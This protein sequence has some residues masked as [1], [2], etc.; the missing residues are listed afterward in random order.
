MCC[1]A[2]CVV[3]LFETSVQ[4]SLHSDTLVETSVQ[5]SLYSDTLVANYVRSASRTQPRVYQHR[6]LLL[7][8]F[9]L[10]SNLIAIKSPYKPFSDCRTVSCLQTKHFTHFGFEAFCT[11]V[12]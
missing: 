1:R 7:L 8:Y 6:I 2:T 11:S 4:Y 9:N 5:Y 12:Y 3:V 10:N